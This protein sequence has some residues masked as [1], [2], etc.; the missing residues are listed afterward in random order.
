MGAP[1]FK[2]GDV[3]LVS[4]FRG[5][6][7][8]FGLINIGNGWDVPGFNCIHYVRFGLVGHVGLLFLEL[9]VQDK[10]NQIQLI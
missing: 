5:I 8:L 10:E 2:I 7:L 1:H 4:L 9:G 6:M 3:P